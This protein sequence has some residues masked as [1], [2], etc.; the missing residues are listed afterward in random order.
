MPL[1]DHIILFAPLLQFYFVPV[2]SGEVMKE[3]RKERK[4]RK[5]KRKKEKKEKKE[6][7][8]NR[9]SREQIIYCSLRAI[10]VAKKMCFYMSTTKHHSLFIRLF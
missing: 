7:R 8:K 9:E 5:K 3:T 1:F 2:G 4:E 10:L 6:G